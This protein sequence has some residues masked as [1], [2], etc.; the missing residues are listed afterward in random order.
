MDEGSASPI[1]SGITTHK[2]P[3]SGFKN[4]VSRRRRATKMSGEEAALRLVT[5]QLGGRPI[6]LVVSEGAFLGGSL[7]FDEATRLKVA[8][9][10]ARRR[11]W[12]CICCINSTGLR[13]DD[14]LETAEL[15]SQVF[16]Q[17]RSLAASE[18]P[19]VALITGPVAGAMAG[20]SLS[21]D[22][23]VADGAGAFGEGRTI[24]ARADIVLPRSD[25]AGWLAAALAVLMG[26]AEDA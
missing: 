2:A 25:V 7:G 14:G 5:G 23:V 24:G 26:G 3:A 17:R 4:R 20:F 15:F 16:E 9:A 1:A 21:A 6:V 13:G 18:V 19:M 11:R 8:L 22:L 12:P 10:L